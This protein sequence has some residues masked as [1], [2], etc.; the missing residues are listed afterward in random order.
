MSDMRQREMVGRSD[1]LTALL[2]EWHDSCRGTTRMVL[3]GGEAG[4][5]KTVLLD[6][7]ARRV[8]G[9]DAAAA[10]VLIGQCVPLGDEGLAY[11]PANGLLRGLIAQVGQAL[12]AEWAGAGWSALA[13]LIPGIVVANGGSADGADRLR[14]FEAVARILEQAARLAPLLVFV[15]DLHWA[16]ES[17]LALLRFVVRLDDAP[18]LFVC[19]YRTDELTRRHRLRPFLAELGRLPGVSRIEL[20]RLD[21]ESVRKLLSEILGASPADSVVSLISERTQGIPY[22]VEELATV[23]SAGGLTLPDTL[24]DALSVRVQRLPD[25]T[26][27]LLR[28]M[29]TG[30]NRLDHALLAAVSDDPRLE[31]HLR[32]AID[33]QVITADE[34][35]Y[36]FRHA[37]LREVIHED[38][39]PG[40]HVAMHARFAQVLEECAELLPEIGRPAIAHHWFAAHQLNRAFASALEVA[41]LRTVPH[42]EAVKLYER[43][44]AI[45]DQVDTPESVAGDRAH[46]LQAAADRARYASDTD[47]GLALIEASIAATPADADPL[48]RSRR[49]CTRGRLMTNWMRPEAFEVLTEAISLTDGLG[50]SPERAHALKCLS[51]YQMLAY[52]AEDAI[53]TATE[54]LAVAD[55]LDLGI[56][57]ADAHNTISCSL[58]A[59]G[60]EDESASEMAEA[61]RLAGGDQK[62]LLRYYV[63]VSDNYQLQGDYE[64]A[65]DEARTGV[66][67][68]AHLGLARS[69]GSILSGNAAEPLLS[70]G[71][72]EEAERLIR[73]GLNLNPPDRHVVHL[74]ML[75]VWLLTMR[76][77]LDA[78]E[79]LLAEFATSLQLVRSARPRQDR[80][81]VLEQEWQAA[82]ALAE[83]ALARGNPDLSWTYVAPQLGMPDPHAPAR[84]YALLFVGAIAAGDDAD[85]I[86]AVRAE[87]AR[88]PRGVKV[89]SAWRPAVEAVLDR[90]VE[91]LRDLLTR[92]VD[93]REPIHLRAW[94]G[95]LLGGRLVRDGV[96]DEA[97]T[98][99]AAASASASSLRSGLLTRWTSELQQRAGFVDRTTTGTGRPGLT[100]RE[101]EVLRLVAAGRT[102]SQIGAELFIS[103]KTASVHVSNILAKL[104]VPNRGQA[105]ARAHASGLA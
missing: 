63:N 7:L 85:R 88:I 29:S 54:Q 81:L 38:L 68:A 57:A 94:L 83:L 31:Q 82:K 2:S 69:T 90:G 10:R 43:A 56:L 76:D 1:E 86:A 4:I 34:T 84:M 42:T 64:L 20:A 33:A 30:G 19:S 72:W 100:P 96:K 74:R 103:T 59:L 26:Q 15:E 78:A 95:Y 22:F 18:I 44:L 12:V 101:T 28:L 87:L 39:L 25:E 14:L 9:P 105:A 51:Q 40:E 62:T 35:G 104:Q 102:N 24:R 91:P 32:D 50:P 36:E 6:A 67:V 99:L 71:Q 89:E 52:L 5:G 65:A 55:A 8:A 23:T 17:T 13:P 79:S 73:R 75:L 60:R 70:L 27:A 49:L 66:E 48:V 58:K 47:R 98:V 46:V 97:R 37:L 77:D 45:W 61:R 21:T 16:D 80:D 92:P 11:A 53:A 93:A 3:L 41:R